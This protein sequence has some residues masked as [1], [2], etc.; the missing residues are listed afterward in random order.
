VY[1]S[2]PR[3]DNKRADTLAQQASSYQIRDFVKERL[4]II[5]EFY[6]KT[7]YSLYG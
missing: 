4:A 5:P 3:E 2:H 7:E 1:H 6:A